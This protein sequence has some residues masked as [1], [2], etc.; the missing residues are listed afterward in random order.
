M[1]ILRTQRDTRTKRNTNAT[2]L[3]VIWRSI[4]VSW[5]SRSS[6]KPF[7]IC[8]SIA[9]TLKHCWHAQAMLKCASNIEICKHRW[10]AKSLLKCASIAGM[11][12]QCWNVSYRGIHCF[13][14]EL[15]FQISVSVLNWA[16]IRTARPNVLKNV[17][18]FEKA[19]AGDTQN[20]LPK[21]F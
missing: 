4:D 12:K 16:F 13:S 1:F 20:V 5:S 17:F 10:N 14:I 19:S 8:S 15:I 6:E 18:V 3:Q 7:W 9:E 2:H 11:L 21:Q